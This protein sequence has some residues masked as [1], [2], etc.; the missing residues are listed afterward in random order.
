[1][2]IVK[3]ILQMKRAQGRLIH[4]TTLG[5]RDESSVT[6]TQEN[7]VCPRFSKTAGKIAPLSRSIVQHD[8]RTVIPFRFLFSGCPLRTTENNTVISSYVEITDVLNLSVQA[9]GKPLEIKITNKY[10]TNMKTIYYHKRLRQMVRTIGT[11]VCLIG[12]ILILLSL[13]G[14]FVYAIYAIIYF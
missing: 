5:M 12:L 10:Y 13:I 3:S 4:F 14:L 6:G 7:K 11:I 9:S 8:S 1:M 2:K